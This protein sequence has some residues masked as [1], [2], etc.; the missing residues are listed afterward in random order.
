VALQNKTKKE[1]LDEVSELRRQIGDLKGRIRK[2]ITTEKAFM[3]PVGLTKAML[4]HANDA[5]YVTQDR[6]IKF[7]NKKVIEISGY[8]SQEL[9]A[10][11]GFEFL[12]PDD[13]PVIIERY[14]RR[15][16]GEEVPD[17][18]PHRLINKW[19]KVKWIEV[20]SVL[21]TWE[22][23]PAQLSFLRDITEKKAAE[24]ALRQSEQ[25]RADI[26]NFLP[27]PTFA[28]D[29]Q[30]RIIAWNHAME[31]LTGI[32]SG[33]MIG[34]GDYEY[35]Y[36]FHG[37]RKPI[38]IDKALHASL[39]VE[40]RYL[41]FLNDG[42]Y[43]LAE[44]ELTFQ[45]RN[46][47]LWCKAALMKDTNGKV[48]GAIESL[49]DIT[50][51][52]ETNTALRVLLKQREDD[53]T[54]IE[55]KFLLNIKELVMPYVYKLKAVHLESPYAANIIAIIENHL[56]EIL[57][58]FLSKL[59]SKYEHFSPREIQVASLIKDGMTTKDIAQVLNISTNS[60]NIYRQNIRKK[61]GLSRKKINIRAF[62]TS[63][64]NN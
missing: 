24:D 37:E 25:L 28:I 36:V 45:G 4:E 11:P 63:L 50:T 44:T 9:M 7:V 56:N 43:L 42:D 3:N 5:I 32:G 30:G 22:G 39:S 34:K 15:M 59:S 29:D 2:G 19:G 51:L 57:S 18:F 16:R 40:E 52:K 33:D 35:A 6:Y 20:A 8:S 13:Q 64:N 27:D 47:T 54:E 61:I 23:R 62:F 14:I 31:G 38:L 21:I 41:S 26:I 58:P 1:L 46:I 10:R 53:K 60:I 49:R 17:L 12:H 48:I 55:E